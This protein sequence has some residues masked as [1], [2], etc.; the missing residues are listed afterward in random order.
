M[1]RTTPS[2]CLV[3]LDE[4]SKREREKLATVRSTIDIERCGV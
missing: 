3:L 2:I 1:E 4:S